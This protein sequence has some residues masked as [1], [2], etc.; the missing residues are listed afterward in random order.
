M[1]KFDEPHKHRK[2]RVVGKN[3]Y[4]EDDELTYRGDDGVYAMTPYGLI[5]G[6]GEGIY[7]FYPWHRVISVSAVGRDKTF[8]RSNEQNSSADETA[9]GR[10]W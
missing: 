10:T 3:T 4:G 1:G 7:T 5:C 2:A 8:L 9:F 6:D